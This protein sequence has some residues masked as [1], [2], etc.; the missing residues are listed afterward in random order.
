MLMMSWSALLAVLL[1]GCGGELASVTGA[2]T[3][4]GQPLAGGPTTRVTVAFLPESGAGVP[5]TALANESGEYEMATGGQQGIKPGVYL[6]AISAT[7]LIPAKSETGMPSGRRLT[8]PQYADPKQ[9]GFRVEV[10]P[11]SNEFDFNL[12]SDGPSHS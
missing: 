8:P 4:D 12:R 7:E 6:V 2:V 5:A 11:G 9:S 3:L 1:S 10:K